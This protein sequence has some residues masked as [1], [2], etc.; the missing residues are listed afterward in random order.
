MVSD[1]G[2]GPVPQGDR[3]PYDH[4]PFDGVH[5]LEGVFLAQGP[6]IEA[7][8]Y[9]PLNLYQIAPT[10]LYLLGITPPASWPGWIPIE[11]FRQDRVA[12]HH[13]VAVAPAKR[14]HAGAPP[15]APAP[16]QEAELERLRSLGYVQ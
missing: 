9:A 5:R 13:T 7:G 4:V 16:H 3:A 10:V 12:Q 8:S 11:L 2:W 1:H 14:P 6:W 15:N